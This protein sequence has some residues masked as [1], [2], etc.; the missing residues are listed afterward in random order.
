MEPEETSIARKQRG[1]KTWIDVSCAVRTT[2]SQQ[3]E[4]TKLVEAAFSL[5]FAP[6]LQKEF[7]L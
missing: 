4:C 6:R 7:I 5:Q 2:F 1:D 3:Q